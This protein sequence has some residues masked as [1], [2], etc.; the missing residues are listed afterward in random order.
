MSQQS[1]CKQLRH[2]SQAIISR[3]LQNFVDDRIW[4]LNLPSYSPVHLLSY[5]HKSTTKLLSPDVLKKCIMQHIKPFSG[6]VIECHRPLSVTSC[7]FLNFLGP[8]FHEVWS[9]V[10][11]CVLEVCLLWSCETYTD[12]SWRGLEFGFPTCTVICLLWSF[13]SY[14]DNIWRK[15]S[16][17]ISAA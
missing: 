13:E 2:V 7:K 12:N 3:L 10:F 16:I 15:A 1:T 17:C 11:H 5:I 4:L 8:E 14:T 9:L 6:M